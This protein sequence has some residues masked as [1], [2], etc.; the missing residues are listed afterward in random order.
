M[1]GI[2]EL[3]GNASSSVF[4][5]GKQGDFFRIS[6]GI[7]QGYLLYRVLFNITMDETFHDHHTSNSICG[8]PISNLR[9]A[10]DIDLMGGTSTVNLKISPTDSM[11]ETKHT[12]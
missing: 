8:R 4:L 6:V 12:G 10:D 7:C 9:F 2:Q 5:N 11:K 1:K 3:Y